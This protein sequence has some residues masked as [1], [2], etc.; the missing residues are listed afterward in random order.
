VNT[1]AMA[2]YVFRCGKA[3]LS[4]L[5]RRVI[6]FANS[7]AIAVVAAPKALKSLVFAAHSPRYN[8][9]LIGKS[10]SSAEAGSARGNF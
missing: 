5:D 7:L 2:F 10:R 4:N 6:E 8:H 3:R 9:S 1:L